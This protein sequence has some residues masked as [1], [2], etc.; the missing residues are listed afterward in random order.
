MTGNPALWWYPIALA[1]LLKA[2]NCPFAK[3]TIVH[4]NIYGDLSKQKVAVAKFT[5]VIDMRNELL[6]KLLEK[7]DWNLPVDTGP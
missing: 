1:I 3:D 6:D 4:D 2:A 5:Q 7:E